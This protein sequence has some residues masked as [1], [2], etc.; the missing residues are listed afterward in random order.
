[1]G[2]SETVYTAYSNTFTKSGLDITEDV[3]AKTNA[4]AE[5]KEAVQLIIDEY[6]AQ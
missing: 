4:D 6:N 5:V 1:M 3:L 2:N